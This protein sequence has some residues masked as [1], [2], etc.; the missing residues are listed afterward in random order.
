MSTI[1]LIE[2]EVDLREFYRE[3][4][5]ASGFSVL[6]AVDGEE[7]LKKALDSGWDLMLLDIMLPRLDGIEV[8]KSVKANSNVQS[9]PVIL[10]TNLDKDE[11]V[12]E[13][14]KVGAESYLVKS[15]ITPNVLVDTINQYLNVAHE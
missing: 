9:K 13:C 15:N 10:L 11:I 2:D 8:L 6:E 4:L 14:L 7:G 5:Q 1:L 3:F 12:Q